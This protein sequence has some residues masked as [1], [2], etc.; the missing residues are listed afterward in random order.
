MKNKTRIM[1]LV[2]NMSKTSDE[3]TR[4]FIADRIFELLNE[5][6]VAIDERGD[7]SGKY[8]NILDDDLADTEEEYEKV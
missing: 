4:L 1:A 3:L 8:E 6:D 5:E 7:D 2:I